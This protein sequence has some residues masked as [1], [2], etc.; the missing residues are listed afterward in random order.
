[1]L[2]ALISTAVTAVMALFAAAPALA[3]PGYVPGEVLVKYA[4]GTTAKA[5]GP[6]QSKTVKVRSGNTVRETVAKL[7]KD[8][9]VA[10]AVPNYIAH[11]SFDPE[12][13]ELRARSGTSTRRS[14]STRPRPGTSRAR[15]AFRAATG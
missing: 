9:D 5:E 12:R 1:M 15:A 8:P 6:V 3:A 13:S 4:G 2:R 14:G 10:Y 11:A 7:R